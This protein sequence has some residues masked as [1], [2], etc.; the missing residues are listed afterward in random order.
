MFQVE[1]VTKGVSLVPENG[2]SLSLYF[3]SWAQSFLLSAVKDHT[4]SSVKLSQSVPSDIS[5]LEAI[6]EA[7][8]YCWFISAYF[9]F[10]IELISIWF[11]MVCADTGLT[12]VI[13]CKPCVT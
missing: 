13:F 1:K 7:R 11:F 8:Y 9:P 4:H 5:T 10:W 3:L 12:G 2:G 6:Q